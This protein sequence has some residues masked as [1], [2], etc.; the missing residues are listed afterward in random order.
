MTANVCYLQAKLDNDW[1]NARQHHRKTR[2]REKR[3]RSCSALPAAAVAA[4][5]AAALLL[6]GVVCSILL[7][8]MI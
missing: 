4:A 8:Y 7:M 3:E 1:D 6:Y 2:A 5:V